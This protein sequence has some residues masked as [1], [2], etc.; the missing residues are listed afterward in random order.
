MQHESHVLRATHFL[1]AAVFT[2]APQNNMG[3]RKYYFL[4]IR[5]DEIW[6]KDNGEGEK[7]QEGPA[8]ESKP[9]LYLKKVQETG[10]QKQSMK[11]FN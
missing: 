8:K 2:I 9:T 11:T 1:N 5:S 7:Q 10:L 6:W 4:Q 3:Q